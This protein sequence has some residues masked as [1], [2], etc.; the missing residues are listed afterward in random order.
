MVILAKANQTMVMK[1]I[2]ILQHAGRYLQHSDKCLVTQAGYLKSF[3]HYFG[4][5]YFLL[6][7]H[8]EAKVDMKHYLL[9]TPEISLES[10]S[11]AGSFLD[12]RDVVFEFLTHSYRYLPEKGCLIVANTMLSGMEIFFTSFA[13]IPLTRERHTALFEDFIDVEMREALSKFNNNVWLWARYSFFDVFDMPPSNIPHGH[14]W[15][16]KTAEK[17]IYFDSFNFS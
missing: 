9:A 17:N 7:K 16:M 1:H 11:L 4:D 5:S 15:W 10:K 6:Q 12:K 13:E 3:F 2:Q 8:K 14:W